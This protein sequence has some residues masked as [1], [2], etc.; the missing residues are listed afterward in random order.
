M[1]PL[2][3]ILE[4]VDKSISITAESSV[5]KHCIKGHYTDLFISEC[6]FYSI[7]SLSATVTKGQTG[8]QKHQQA[9]VTICAP[10]IR[11]SSSQNY[12]SNASFSIFKIL[13][14]LSYFIQINLSTALNIRMAFMKACLRGFKKSLGRVRKKKS[15]RFSNV[16]MTSRFQVLDLIVNKPFKEQLKQCHTCLYYGGPQYVPVG[17]VRAVPLAS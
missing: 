5:G 1:W 14:S 12:L 4:R 9:H 17:C 16:G 6:G 3:T 2:A 13:Q 15:Q 7:C 11:T 10:N 8:K